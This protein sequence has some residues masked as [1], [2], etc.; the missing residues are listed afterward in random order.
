[1]FWEFQRYGTSI[2]MLINIYALPQCL[3]YHH[4]QKLCTS[5][6]SF[7]ANRCYWKRAIKGNRWRVLCVRD[8]RV[9]GYITRSCGQETCMTSA[10][11]GQ[12]LTTNLNVA[13]AHPFL[14]MTR[15]TFYTVLNITWWNRYWWFPI[16]PR[17][18][19]QNLKSTC[20]WNKSVT[21]FRPATVIF[22]SLT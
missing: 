8:W 16:R 11:D 4:G 15:G 6:R 10:W 18:R 1:M 3:T 21:C 5:H 17:L 22:S 20:A 19:D 13:L 12:P 14:Y 9:M 7:H 2:N